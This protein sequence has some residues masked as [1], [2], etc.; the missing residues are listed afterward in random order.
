MPISYLSAAQIA[1]LSVST[2]ERLTTT[3]MAGLRSTRR[4]QA[5]R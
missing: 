3:Q 4:R 1:A 2:V 5:S